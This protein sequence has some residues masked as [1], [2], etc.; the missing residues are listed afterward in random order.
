MIWLEDDMCFVAERTGQLA[1]IRQQRK[2]KSGQAM[3]LES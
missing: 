1:Q 3:S 2:S